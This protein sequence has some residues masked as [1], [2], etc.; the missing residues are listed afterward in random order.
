MPPKCQDWDL[1]H[2]PR[3][4]SVAQPFGGR[5]GVW[6]FSPP[7]KKRQEMSLLA[8]GTSTAPGGTLFARNV[9]LG[10]LPFCILQLAQQSAPP[11][12]RC[13]HTWHTTVLHTA[14]H[15]LSGSF[16]PDQMSHLAHYRS[17]HCHLFPLA[18]DPQSACVTLGTL[19]F[20]ILQLNPKP[21]FLHTS[22]CHT[23]H[24]T[25]LHTATMDGCTQA[26]YT[27]CSHTWHTTV[28]HTAT[29]HSVFTMMLASCVTLGTLPFCILQPALSEQPAGLIVSHTWHTTVLHTATRLST[30]TAASVCS[31]T[32]GTL[33]FCI[34]QQPSAI[35]TLDRP[36]SHTWHTTVLH[37]ATRQQRL[38]QDHSTK[39]TLG[40][41]PF[42]ILQ[43]L[44]EL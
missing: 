31:V 35:L 11:T 41:L 3:I 25:V 37:T 30:S 16:D 33:P 29:A 15:V 28:L 14:T 38:S 32:L 27:I 20:C 23:W 34:L 13:R 21:L 7:N 1:A 43:P 10:T 12:C 18:P 39:V 26:R 36:S 19:P 8:L 4:Y 17:A 22:I 40:T 42:C 44:P 5:Q 24:T 6:L 9:T 2:R